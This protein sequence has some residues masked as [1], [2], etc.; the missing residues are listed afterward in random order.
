LC[1]PFLREL[2]DVTWVKNLRAQL[3]EA[4]F[5]LTII[6]VSLPLDLMKENIISRGEKRDAGKLQNWSAYSSLISSEDAGYRDLAD[7]VLVNDEQGEVKMLA[8]LETLCSL[9]E[10]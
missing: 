7:L 3:N 2:K 6:W 4:D 10:Q 5:K 8:A 1:A 9:L